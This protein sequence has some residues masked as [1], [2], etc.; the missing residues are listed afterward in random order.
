MAK[1]VVLSEG[2]TGR[3][4]ELTAERTT[5]GRVEDNT[6]QLAEPSVSSH[7]CE[8]LQ[9]GGE[10]KI[11]DLNSTNGTYIEGKQI[12]E[13]V[14]KPGQTLRLGKVDLKLEGESAAP[15]A[16]KKSIEQTLVVP[17]GVSLDQL[18]Q[19]PKASG[20]DTAAKGFAKKDNRTNKLFIGVV[21]LV[22]VGI[23]AVIAWLIISGGTSG[24]APSR[25]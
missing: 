20:F 9:Q 7:H 14:L 12:T 1:L 21:I 22:V 24:A 2:L 13:G 10:I 19:G 4:H 3:S 17:R 23:L 5:V 15:A 11:K 6:F 25:R 8:I 16:G 18:E